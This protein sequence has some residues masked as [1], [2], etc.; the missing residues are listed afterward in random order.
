MT[1]PAP[2]DPAPA[3]FNTSAQQDQEKADDAA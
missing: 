2:V 3:I 1:D